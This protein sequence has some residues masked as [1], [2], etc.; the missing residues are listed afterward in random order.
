MGVARAVAA[1]VVAD[2]AATVATVEDVA[3]V[4]IAAI[5]AAVRDHSAGAVDEAVED[6]GERPR[7]GREEEDQSS[8]WA[9]S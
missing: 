8:S 3:F 1:G 2:V 5:A 7:W 4:A 9:G 6:D